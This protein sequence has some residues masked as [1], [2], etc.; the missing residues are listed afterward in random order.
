MSA[1][2]Y[3]CP[4]CNKLIGGRGLDKHQYSEPCLDRQAGRNEGLA[5]GFDDGLKAAAAA[6]VEVALT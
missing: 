5:V 2:R 3:Y 4:T 1:H 6:I